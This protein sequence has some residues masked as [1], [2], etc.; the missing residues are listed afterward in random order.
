MLLP[1]AQGLEQAAAVPALVA[2]EGGGAEG[3]L[4][5]GPLGGDL[6]R[7]A[8]AFLEGGTGLWSWVLGGVNV[9]SLKVRAGL[10]AL[11]QQY[12]LR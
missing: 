2:D 6:S 3:G 4:S 12:G 11:V 10:S 7:Q 9:G 8:A 5:L 1:L